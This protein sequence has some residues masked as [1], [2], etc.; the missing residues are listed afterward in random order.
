M[1]SGAVVRSTPRRDG[2]RPHLLEHGESRA[3]NHP[4]AIAPTTI[5]NSVPSTTGFGNGRS[6]GQ[7]DRSCSQAKNRRNGRRSWLTGSR[8]VPRS[9]G[10]SASSA[11]S[12]DRWVAGPRTRTTTSRPTPAS[13]HRL[14]GSSTRIAAITARSAPL[15][16]APREARAPAPT[17]SHPR[18]TN[19][20]SGPRSCRN[21][22][23]R[24]RG[25]PPSSH[26]AA[27]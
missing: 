20:R 4:P 13:T 10:K 21:T 17:M 14:D 1:G 2:P 6:G 7:W 9:I 11:S 3:S 24:S 27:R 19:R 5:N 22:H 16:T 23:R 15:P 26:R 18:P 8:I 25:N 12:S